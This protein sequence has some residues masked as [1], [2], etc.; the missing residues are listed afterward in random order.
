MYKNKSKKKN[1]LIL[2]WYEVKLEFHWNQIFLIP[3][4]VWRHFTP[5]NQL[6]GREW[7]SCHTSISSAAWEGML[8]AAE[9]TRPLY[10]SS[11]P[12]S[13][14]FSTSSLLCSSLR[15]YLTVTRACR[16]WRLWPGDWGPLHT[17]FTRR[18]TR[19]AAIRAITLRLLTWEEKKKL[20][21]CL[22]IRPTSGPTPKNTP[23]SI[24]KIFS[25][26]EF[27][28]IE[29][30]LSS[31]EITKMKKYINVTVRVCFLLKH[32]RNVK[33]LIQI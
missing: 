1:V 6:L 4:R 7:W 21:S 12:Q 16:R 33:I 23:Q 26:Q 17:L 10:S 30:F 14:H 13:I 19:W 15:L 27:R 9:L 29:P 31:S 22:W 25:N 5:R 32:Y 3:D 18:P 20:S 2:L 24:Y 28:S 8:Q 11:S